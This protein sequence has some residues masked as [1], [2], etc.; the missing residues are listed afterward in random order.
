MAYELT[1]EKIILPDPRLN[2][3]LVGRSFY[4]MDE[5]NIHDAIPN[6]RLELKKAVTKILKEYPLNNQEGLEIT[7]RRSNNHEKEI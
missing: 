1:I 4:R 7:I 6:D 3:L 2:V 5:K